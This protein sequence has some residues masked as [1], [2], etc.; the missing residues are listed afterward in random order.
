MTRTHSRIFTELIG[1]LALCLIALPFPGTALLAAEDEANAAFTQA[2]ATAGKAGYEENC[3]SCH[4]NGL[5]GFGLVPT[6][7]GAIFAGRWGDKPA[8]Q[9]ANSVN[10]MPPGA[11][12]SLDPSEYTQILAYV[13]EHNGMKAGARALPTGIDALAALTIPTSALSNAAAESSAPLLY[14]SD[15]P[16]VS[17]SRL[18]SLTAVTDDM[19]LNPP[20]DDW[21]NWRR[22]RDAYAHS[23]LNQIN[24]ENVED[25]QLAWSWSLPQ[26]ENMMTPIIHDGVMFAYSY[27]D[28]LQAMDASTGELLWSFQRELEGGKSPGMK[29]GAAIYADK[30]VIA[31]SDIHLIALEAKTGKIA[32]DH[33]VDS[34]GEDS[35]LFRS[36]P[37]IANGKAIIGLTGRVAVEGGDFIFAVDMETGQEAW[38]FYTIARPDEPGGNT[39]NGLPLEE[40]NGGSIWIPGTFDADLNLVYFGPAPTYDTNP[41]RA[42]HPDPSMT[43]D[44]LYT[45]STVALDADT[46]ELAWHYQ[47]ISNDQLDHDWAFERQIMDLRID[48]VNR[49]AVVTGGKLAIFEALDAATGEYLFSFDLDMQNVV[50]EIDARTGRK[51]INPAAIPELDQVISQYSMPGICPDWLGARNMQAT[52]YNPDTK[53]LYIPISDTCLDDDSG[54]RWQKYPDDSTQGSWGIIK[55]VN[56][57][58]QQVIWEQRQSGPQASANMTTASGLLFIGSVDRWFKALDQDSGEVLWER[59]LDN[60]LNSYPVTYRVDGRQYVAVAT[61]QGGIHTRTM[62]TA[63]GIALP[64]AGATMWVFALPD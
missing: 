20:A 3:A 21:L 44:A 5:E 1:P 45:N 7:T 48:G 53:M 50:T 54:E 33:K 8:D 46:G 16:L 62:K 19:L 60:A 57:Q 51:S 38:R 23:P 52:A 64:V 59:R 55:A 41:L 35:F 25:L 9:L 10:R 6:L 40:R 63:A 15:G 43:R 58:T 26:G 11:E 61:N 49:K 31:T 56:L 13:L 36:A 27:G 28:V 18:E 24:K 22:T 32:W 29:K 12:G 14:N 2:Q 39:W 42:P 4:G 17:S 37:L 34:G 47:H 30:I